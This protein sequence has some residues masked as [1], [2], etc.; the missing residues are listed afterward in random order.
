MRFLRL[1]FGTA[2]LLC[3]AGAFSL[4][5][6]QQGGAPR[7]GGPGGGPGGA[8]PGG[9][10]PGGQPGNGSNGNIGFPGGPAN[11]PSG[12]PP[13]GSA[14]DERGTVSTMPAGLQL[15]PPGRWWDD[16]HFAKDLKLRPDQQKHMDDVFDQNRTT[17]LRNYENLQQEE[18]KMEALVHGS[19]LDEATLFAQIDRVAQARAALEK[20]NTHL[21]LQ[22]RSE[23]STDQIVRLE[24]H[25]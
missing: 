14:P 10:G 12:G 16:K 25:H 2:L 21:M 15:G 17:L 20:A 22:I 7:G 9:M 3:C 5:A 6:A 19:V 4:A 23:M 1:A 11:N 24:Q 8:P 13:P 18:Q